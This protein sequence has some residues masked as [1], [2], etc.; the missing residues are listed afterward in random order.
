MIRRQIVE[1]EQ[2][3]GEDEV[4]IYTLTTTNWASSP[5]NTSA[6]IFSHDQ[7]DGSYT[8]VTA[9]NMSGSTSVSGDVITLPTITG[10]SDGTRYR[11]EVQFTVDGSTYEPYAWIK[12]DR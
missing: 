4:L 12:G 5:T 2:P 7:T 10:L 9:T 8:D 3:Q 6:K 1:G 11:V